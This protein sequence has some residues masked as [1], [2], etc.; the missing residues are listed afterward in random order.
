MDCRHSVAVALQDQ[1]FVSILCIGRAHYMRMLMLS[2][3]D[4]HT[5]CIVLS[6]S[7][8]LMV[9]YVTSIAQDPLM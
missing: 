2:L 8:S 1:E 4:H 6:A 7:T 9:L 3:E 5:V